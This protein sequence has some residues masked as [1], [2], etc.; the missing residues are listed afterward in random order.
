MSKQGEV[1]LTWYDSETEEEVTHTFPAVNEVCHKCEGYGSHLNPSIGEHAY[2]MEEFNESFDDEGKEEYFKRGGIYDVTCSVCKGN[3]VVP[4]VDE[5]HLTEEQKKLYADY[6]E[7]EE[8]QARSDA[9]DRQTRY[10]ESGGY[11]Y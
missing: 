1:E 5:E 8:E 2:S 11:D 6:Q 3:K 9:E 7:H 4:S 10:Y